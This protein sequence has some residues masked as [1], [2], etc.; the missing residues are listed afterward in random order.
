MKEGDTPATMKRLMDTLTSLIALIVLSPLYITIMVL[1]KLD[2][3]G[4]I[5]YRGLRAG[6]RGKPFHILKFRTM[7][8]DAEKIGGPDTPADDPRIT[9]TGRLLRRFNLD[10]LPQFINVL[11]GEM[12][13]VGP[14]PERPQFIEKLSDDIP[15]YLH[16]LGLKPGLTGVAQ[17]INGYDNNLASFRR[18]VALDLLYLQNCCFWNDAKIML[19]T[20][21]VV[22]TGKGA[23]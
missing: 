8:A 5:L 7:V 17:V 13:L 23:I 15:D 11:K 12:S 3:Q 6:H 9:K 14:R 22:L 19:R 1:I 2:S 16:R 18:K 4:P 10:E 21:G 20:V